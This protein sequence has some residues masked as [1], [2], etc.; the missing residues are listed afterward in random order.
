MIKEAYGDVAL[1]CLTV[2]ECHKLFREGRE[3]VE[4]D[5]RS[6]R[7]STSRINENVIKAKALLDSDRRLNICLIVNELK[8]SY[9]TI[10][11]Y[12][13]RGFGRTKDV[14]QVCAKNPE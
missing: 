12:Y 8:I 6:G 3:L 14:P 4:D 11:E 10:Q 9:G 1:S 13:Y 5:E 7:P 2:F